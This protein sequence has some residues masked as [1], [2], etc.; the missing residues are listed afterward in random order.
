MVSWPDNQEE[1]LFFKL[2]VLA[3]YWW[4][5]KNSGK[6]KVCFIIVDKISKML[7]EQIYNNY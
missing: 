6:T 2:F 3:G 1:V 7:Y 5:F 4:L